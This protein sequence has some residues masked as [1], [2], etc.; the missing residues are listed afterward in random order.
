M[1]FE[2]QFRLRPLP[3]IPSAAAPAVQAVLEEGAGDPSLGFIRDLPGVWKGSGFNVIWRPNSTPGQD[4]FLELNLTTEELEFSESIGEI[5]NRG[6]LQGDIVMHGITYMQK[7]GDANLNAGIHIEPGIW[8]SVPKTDN[9]AEPATVVR[10]ATIPHGTSLLAQGTGSEVA[11]GPNI[12]DNNITPFVIGDPTQLI[13]TFPEPNLSVASDFR[14]PPP[15]LVGITQAMVDNPNSTLKAALQ[16]QEIA[17]T[18]T[19]DVST[20]PPTPIVGGGTA[21][22]AFL[23]GLQAGPNADAVTA[24]STF[25]IERVVGQGGGPDFLQLQ[26]TQLVLLNFN[27]LSWPHVSVATL[28]KQ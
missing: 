9:P 6:F 7:I 18:V 16:S 25:W 13:T 19:L 2:P 21:N 17:S 8:A 3:D 15:Q 10:M 14:S 11:G 22:T 20:A 28:R 27:T 23:K 12:P 4:R 5:P 1:K 26:Y 24:S